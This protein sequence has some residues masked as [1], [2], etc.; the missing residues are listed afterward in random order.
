MTFLNQLKNKKRRKCK[1]QNV[2]KKE[3]YSFTL[4]QHFVSNVSLNSNIETL[5]IGVIAE[6]TVLP[7]KSMAPLIIFTSSKKKI[8]KK[9][10]QFCKG[11]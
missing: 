3:I 6:E 8:L 5:S 9:Q 2:I 7:L 11:W 1:N 10:F 4:S